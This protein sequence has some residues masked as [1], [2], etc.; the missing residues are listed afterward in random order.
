MDETTVVDSSPAIEK[1]KK[2][3]GKILKSPSAGERYSQKVIKRRDVSS[4]EDRQLATQT[5]LLYNEVSRQKGSYKKHIEHLVQANRILANYEKEE[6]VLELITKWRGICQAGM[7]YMLN[8]TLIK[9]DKMGGYEELLRRECEA[10]KRKLEYHFGDT[11]EE[12]MEAVFESEDFKALSEEV[13][14]EYRDKMTEQSKEAQERKEKEFAALETKMKA[15]VGR[16]MT[17]QELSKRMK[18]D[19][20]TIFPD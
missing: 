8:S 5:R 10:E 4:I 20:S 9:I 7:S 18:M 2:C 11:L 16:E 13:Q 19:Y 6:R 1:D 3:V 14:Q 12:E 17:M 15:N